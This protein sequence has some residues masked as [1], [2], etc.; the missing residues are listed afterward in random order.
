MESKQTLE[1]VLASFHPFLFLVV[2]DRKEAEEKVRVFFEKDKENSELFVYSTKQVTLPLVRDIRSLSLTGGQKKK[3]IVLS[4]YTFLHDA[5]NALL[6][7]LEEVG[8]N[9]RF[10]FLAESKEGILPTVLSRA[11][12][13]DLAESEG[14][15][16]HHFDTKLF[17][18]SVPSLRMEITFVKVLLAKK[19]D[20]DKKDR[21]HFALFLDELLMALPHDEEGFRG[22]KELLTFLPYTRDTGSSP[23][24]I[25]EYL[26]LALPVVLE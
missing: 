7:A 26:A 10:I 4:F 21:E 8:A 20:D 12:F 22:R 23:K 24:M 25:L 5:Q 6:K 19:D 9:A 1:T 11:S 2:E 16:K 17:L 3:V 15:K 18:S 13:F 14:V